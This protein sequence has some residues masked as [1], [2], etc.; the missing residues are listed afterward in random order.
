M[1]TV[2]EL[3]RWRAKQHAERVALEY[4]GRW[5]TYA[6]LDR[7][8]NQVAN[9]L[10][11]CGVQPG[12]HVC[13]LDHNHAHMFET[14]F[15][16]AKAGA[17]FTP[18]NWRL[19]PPEMAF[20]INDGKAR[21]VFA[22]PSFSAALG[23]IEQ[24]LDT[25]GTIVCYAEA[26][27]RWQPYETWRD[28]AATTDPRHDGGE[29][30]TAWQLYT[31]GTTGTPKGA[32]ITH[33]NLLTVLANGLLPGISVTPGERALVC[34][35][36]YHIGGAGYALTLLYAGMTAVV[37]NVFDPAQILRLLEERRITQA[38]LVPTMINFLLQTPACAATDF[39]ALKT[40]I[41]GASAIPVDLLERALAGFGCSFV[42]AYG[43]TE[44]T[45]AICYL[46]AADH[47]PGSARLKSAGQPAFG[48]D[49]RTVNASGDLCSPGEVGEIV[50]RGDAVMKGYWNQP[51]ATRAAIVD[52]WFHTGDAGYFDDAG[53]LY[54]HDRVKDMIVSGAENIYPAEVERVLAQH[55]AVFDV[56]VIGV[57]D[58]RWGEAVKAVVQLR[59]GAQA[60]ESE[61]IAHCRGRIA[62]Y[63]CPKS[64][65][66]CAVIPRNPS[67]KA[68]KRELREPYWRNRSRRV[69]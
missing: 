47:L 51:E 14:I 58:E 7:R 59:P 1:R 37:A 11:R 48:I 9:A 25:A 44:T 30:D 55:P 41:Y 29:D 32:E 64:V 17:V 43:L 60:S 38:F 34:L 62:D 13:V 66:F 63:K 56:A 4:A 24:Q 54:I 23:S 31:S 57:P 33:R 22:G 10:V 69:N 26:H 28:A 3:I 40:I 15:G 36:L 18:I 53:Y 2:A 8:A 20:L 65:D 46:P 21:V 27:E 42:Q 35:P 50:V 68:L 61:L 6:E 12:E 19:A 67:G 45:G 39:S 16:I 49:I 5:T 52:G